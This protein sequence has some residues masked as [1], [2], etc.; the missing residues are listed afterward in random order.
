M[1]HYDEFF[2]AREERQ[3]QDER[4]RRQSWIVTVE[5]EVQYHQVNSRKYGI[6]RLTGFMPT[7]LPTPH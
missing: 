6:P 3:R 4:E 1:G 5:Q 7:T 2:E